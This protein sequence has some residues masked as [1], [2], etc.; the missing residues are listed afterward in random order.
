MRLTP[1]PRTNNGDGSR[2]FNI[3]DGTAT[4]RTV[5]ISGLTLANGDTSVAG[6]AIRTTENLALSSSSLSG[7]V[8]SVGGGLYNLVQARLPR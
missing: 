1:R 2:I 7:N 6:G 3:D 4:V 8:S 5:S